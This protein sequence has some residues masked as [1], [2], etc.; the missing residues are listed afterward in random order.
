MVEH[1]FCKFFETVIFENE[2]FTN[3]EWF[4]KR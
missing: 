1:E 3:H 2:R 4:I